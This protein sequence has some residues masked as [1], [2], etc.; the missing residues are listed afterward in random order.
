MKEDARQQDPPISR[1]LVVLAGR[2]LRKL[3]WIILALAAFP[4]LFIYFEAPFTPLHGLLAAH[5]MQQAIENAA[6][7][8][9]STADDGVAL[10]LTAIQLYMNV[11]FLAS[12]LIFSYMLM[13]RVPD[14][15]EN[16]VYERVL[17]A[18]FAAGGRSISRLRRRG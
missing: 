18:L 11:S 13:L 3:S 8:G 10:V 12:G 14:T 7:S 6:V 16:R 2:Q 15:P 9:A 1:A 4:A 5:R 17:S